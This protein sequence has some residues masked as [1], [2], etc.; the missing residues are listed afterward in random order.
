MK[1][2]KAIITVIEMSL[3]VLMF[4]SVS[5][6]MTSNPVFD[7]PYQESVDS[8]L[9]AIYQS[10]DFSQMVLSEN[11]S[12]FFPSQDWTSISRIL[13]ESYNDY[14]LIISNTT[15]SKKIYICQARYSKINSQRIITISNNTQFEFRKVTLGVCF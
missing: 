4:V 14:E 13:N 6:Y 10:G 15:Y 12:A 9:D 2:K 5:Y 3:L 7:H 11:L 8:M 1:N